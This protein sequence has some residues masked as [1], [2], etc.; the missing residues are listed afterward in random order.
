MC[1][2]HLFLLAKACFFL[3]QYQKGRTDSLW[4]FRQVPHSP[5]LRTYTQPM[6]LFLDGNYLYVYERINL[7]RFCSCHHLKHWN[8]LA[9]CRY[10]FNMYVGSLKGH[11]NQWASLLFQHVRVKELKGTDWF[12][13]RNLYSEGIFTTSLEFEK[14]MIGLFIRV[15]SSIK[16]AFLICTSK[17]N[18]N[19]IKIPQIFLGQ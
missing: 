3:L 11:W 8:L 15:Y 1:L 18:T 12:L 14:K 17:I 7:L 6:P 13:W 2:R 10:Y 16:I 4:H 5:L 19:Y 9:P